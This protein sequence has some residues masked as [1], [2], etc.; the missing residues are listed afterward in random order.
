MKLLFRQM[1]PKD[2]AIV[3]SIDK[4]AFSNPWPENAFHYELEKNINAR[5]WV[6]EIQDGDK[7]ELITYAVIWIIL[8]EA[9]IGTIA[10][11][12]Q[13]QQRGF[14]QQFLALICKQLINEKITKIFLEVR[15][16][17][18]NALNLYKKFGFT[19]DGERKHY[20]HDNDE[21]AI[22]MSSALDENIF[23]ESF[24]LDHQFTYD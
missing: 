7:L 22:L 4:L 24:L 2:L 23:Y 18:I 6:G 15:A 3:T 21:T 12:P 1:E 13:Y 5:L 8:D 11:L 19:V 14:G 20:Y 9:H 16:S 17:N 10:I